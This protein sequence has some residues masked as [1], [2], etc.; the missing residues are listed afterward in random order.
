MCVHTMY[1]AIHVCVGV[2][3]SYLSVHCI[4]VTMHQHIV[5]IQQPQY[6]YMFGLRYV[7]ALVVNMNALTS[8]CTSNKHYLYGCF[9]M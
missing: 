3:R 7:V 2:V 6:Q 5:H 4:C 9:M 1:I 8:Y